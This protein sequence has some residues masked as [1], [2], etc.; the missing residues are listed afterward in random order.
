MAPRSAFYALPGA[1]NLGVAHYASERAWVNFK[2]FGLALLTFAFAAA[3][4]FWLTRARH[5]GGRRARGALTMND[6]LIGELRGALQQRSSRARSRSSTTAPG[7]CGHA[8]AR[9]GGHFR[10]S[11]RGRCFRGRSQLERHRLVYAAVAPL[12]PGAVARAQH[13]GAHRR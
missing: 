13:D 8:G 5:A 9:S 11:A 4:A 10:V 12:M 6:A 7:T 2:V 3:Q 1:L